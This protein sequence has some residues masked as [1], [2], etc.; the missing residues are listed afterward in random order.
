MNTIRIIFFYFGQNQ[1]SSVLQSPK[2]ALFWSIAVN[3][4]GE[5]RDLDDVPFLFLLLHVVRLVDVGQPLHVSHLNLG[6]VRDRVVG[7][8]GAGE[9]QILLFV[10]VMHVQLQ[11]EGASGEA[12]GVGQLEAKV[13][14]LA[15]LLV[16]GE[17][18]DG[19]D[20]SGALIGSGGHL[21]LPLV[22]AAGES[23]LGAELPGAEGGETDGDAP[24]DGLGAIQLCLLADEDGLDSVHLPAGDGGTGLV[25][26]ARYAVGLPVFESDQHGGVRHREFLGGG[27]WKGGLGGF[28]LGGHFGELQKM[29]GGVGV[30][31]KSVVSKLNFSAYFPFK[32]YPYQCG[33]IK[34]EISCCTWKNLMREKYAIIYFDN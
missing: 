8:E 21:H 10:R 25:H 31:I 14:G 27:F 1:R 15:G 26:L 9:S 3:S 19:G 28:R 34:F 29:A 24:A 30:S 6:H 22:G 20:V 33:K 23:V 13:P 12:D 16:V 5:S 11:D 17:G 4:V 18:P 7:V 32:Y 2:L